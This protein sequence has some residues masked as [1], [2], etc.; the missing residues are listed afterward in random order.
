MIQIIPHTCGKIKQIH[1]LVVKLKKTVFTLEY[2]KVQTY[3][4]LKFYLYESR[5]YKK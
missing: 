4:L 3:E 1:T 2:N 5:K